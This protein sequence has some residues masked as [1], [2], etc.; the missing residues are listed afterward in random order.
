MTLVSYITTNLL[1][2]QKKNKE[3]ISS[4]IMNTFSKRK[5]KTENGAF[6]DFIK[7]TPLSFYFIGI[8]SRTKLDKQ[9][10]LDFF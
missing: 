7:N 6:L 1:F 2:F 9:R 4:A 5:K 10:V 8:F 3:K